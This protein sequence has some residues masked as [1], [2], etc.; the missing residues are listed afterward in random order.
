M[1]HNT[2]NPPSKG[3][4]NQHRHT[5]RGGGGEE[6]YSEVPTIWSN[7]AYQGSMKL[8]SCRVRLYHRSLKRSATTASTA[9]VE[10]LTWASRSS[11]VR[12][13]L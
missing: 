3:H 9:S 7:E 2:V 11:T 13:G 1:L 4:G 6:S 8:Q 5:A 10:P 12:D